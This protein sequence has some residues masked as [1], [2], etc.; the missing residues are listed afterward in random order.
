MTITSGRLGRAGIRWGALLSIVSLLAALLVSIGV[1][2]SSASD[3]GAGKT[4]VVPVTGMSCVSCA[5]AIKR[6]VKNLNGVSEVEVSLADRTMRVTYAPDVV[7]PDRF[8][9]AVNALGY[10]AGRPVAEE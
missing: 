2:M 6:S 4:V 5:A 9:A 8:I 3:N 1:G 7:S 10:Q